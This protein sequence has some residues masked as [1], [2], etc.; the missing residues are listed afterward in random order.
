[1]LYV[2]GLPVQTFDIQRPPEMAPIWVKSSSC[3]ARAWSTHILTR[4]VFRRKMLSSK[5]FVVL[6]EAHSGEVGVLIIVLCLSM[7]KISSVFSLPKPSTHRQTTFAVPSGNV[8]ALC[9]TA[10][11]N[12]SWLMG[13][14]PA[15]GLSH[16]SVFV[17]A[18]RESCFPALLMVCKVL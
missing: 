8:C 15:S 9:S 18:P 3:L 13:V 2:K 4:S 7:L 17:A 14:I 5:V 11:L 6:V 10:F 1:M 16:S 12:P